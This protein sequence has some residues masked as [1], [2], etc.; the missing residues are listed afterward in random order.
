LTAEAGA[1]A[2]GRRPVPPAGAAA[3]V[4]RSKSAAAELSAW[5]EDSIATAALTSDIGGFQIGRRTSSRGTSLTGGALSPFAARSSGSGSFSGAG[6]AGGG[7][8]S[9]APSSALLASLRPGTGAYQQLR[10]VPSGPP[11][12]SPPASPMPSP[13]QLGTPRRVAWADAAGVRPSSAAASTPAT[14][15]G[16]AAAALPPLPQGP[17]AARLASGGAAG[18]AGRGGGLRL[19]PAGVLSDDRL[20]IPAAALASPRLPSARSLGVPAR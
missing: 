16:D 17:P 10:G 19:P 6:A 4:A 18:A 5:L 3:G 1:E 8:R 20:L 9:G 7:G 12:P 14:P 15:R 13:R 11:L 2:A